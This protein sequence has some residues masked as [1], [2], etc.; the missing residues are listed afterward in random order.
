MEFTEPPRRQPAESIVPMINVV[1][2]L[3][4]FFLMTAQIAPPE[5]FAVTPPDASSETPVEGEFTL[6]LDADGQLAFS[7]AL[8]EEPAL[9]ALKAAHDAYC[10]EADCAQAPPVVLRADQGVPAKALAALLPKIGAAGFGQAL[11]VTAAP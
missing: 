6:Y 4:V 8:G 3:L 9:A 10:A 1:F 2:L 7:D 11:L 5:P